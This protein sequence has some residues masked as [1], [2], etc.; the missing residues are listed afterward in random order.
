M[1][2]RNSDPTICSRIF[3]ARQECGCKWKALPKALEGFAFT[4]WTSDAT[5]KHCHRVQVDGEDYAQLL[6]CEVPEEEVAE[7]ELD[8]NYA[9]D[10]PK[11]CN[12]RFAKDVVM[13]APIRAVEIDGTC[14]TDTPF[15]KAFA[16]DQ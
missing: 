2:F 8:L 4:G 15:C 16:G 14:R 3:R 7:L 12:E 10:L 13:K 9:E 1:S 11:F 5:P 6:V